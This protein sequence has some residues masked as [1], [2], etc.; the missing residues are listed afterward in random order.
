MKAIPLILRRTFSKWSPDSNSQTYTWKF[1]F[2]ARDVI[3]ALILAAA[4]TGFSAQHP[5]LYGRLARDIRY[6]DCVY[7]ADAAT[8]LAELRVSRTDFLR[9]Y[10]SSPPHSPFCTFLA[11][12]GFGIF[13]LHDWV[14]YAANGIVLAAFMVMI[15]FLL[16]PVP[17]PA[18]RALL[19][20]G[21]IFVPFSY[22]AIRDCK[23]IKVSTE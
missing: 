11:M 10:A 23:E 4:Y 20:T 14:P 5:M 7:F 18:A 8:R 2:H 19:L 6:D 9:A 21:F 22:E 13:G 1:Q 17:S 16:S 3:L 12:A 15:T